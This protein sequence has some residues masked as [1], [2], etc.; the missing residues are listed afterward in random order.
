MVEWDVGS[1]AYKAVWVVRELLVKEL[2][3]KQA[4]VLWNS[5]CFGTELKHVPEEQTKAEAVAAWMNEGYNRGAACAYWDRMRATVPKR[6]K[7]LND[8]PSDVREA[9][10]KRLQASFDG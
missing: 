1:S 5:G 8:E 10:K 2:G 7:T 9:L 3:E 4:G 6:H